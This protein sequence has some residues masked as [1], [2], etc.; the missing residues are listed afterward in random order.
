MSIPQAARRFWPTLASIVGLFLACL[1]NAAAFSETDQ[2]RTTTDEGVSVTIAGATTASMGS[3]EGRS[4]LGSELTAEDGMADRD[5]PRGIAIGRG[6]LRGTIAPDVP[7]RVEGIQRQ[8]SRTEKE[9]EPIAIRVAENAALMQR[10]RGAVGSENREL[11]RD[12]RHEVTRYAQQLDPTITY[13]EGTTIVVALLKMVG[14]FK[15]PRT[16]KELEPLA[17]RIAENAALMQRLRV[18]IAGRKDNRVVRDVM[19]EVRSA[20]QELDP[21]I[22]YE[23]Q[24]TIIELLTQMASQS[25]GQVGGS[26]G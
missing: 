3:I 11:A 5:K 15:A 22:L 4:M 17:M 14:H 21:T 8:R 13:D 2:I 16:A 7:P 6:D 25:K 19:A 1:L 24:T 12:V 23:E 20:A 26:N 18:A 9:L 10:F